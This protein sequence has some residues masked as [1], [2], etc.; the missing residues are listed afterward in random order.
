MRQGKT[1]TGV[2]LTPE[3]RHMLEALRR[4]EGA[5]SWAEILR[6]LLHRAAQEEKEAREQAEK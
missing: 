3:E 1:L 2:L 6:L 4:R 5:R